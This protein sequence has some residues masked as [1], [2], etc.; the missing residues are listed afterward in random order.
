MSGKGDSI[1]GGRGR[2]SE[3]LSPPDLLQELS[4]SGKP[5][6]RVDLMAASVLQLV[7]ATRLLGQSV[8]EGPLRTAVLK[9]AAIAEI[10]ARDAIYSPH[11]ASSRRRSHRYRDDERTVASETRNGAEDDEARDKRG[12]QDVSGAQE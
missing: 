4:D 6:G 9:A 10:R 7:Y 8:D 3:L 1:A 11:K 2:D 12:G 5:P